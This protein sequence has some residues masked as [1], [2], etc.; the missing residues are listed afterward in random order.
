MAIF[1]V[2]GPPAAGKTTW[3]LDNARHGDIIIDYDRIA[4]ALTVDSDGHQHPRTILGAA[5]AARQAA[6]DHA[7]TTTAD[8]DVYI[9]HTRLTPAV[10]ARYEHIGARIVTIDPGI[11]TVLARAKHCRPW[12]TTQA[13]KDWY[14]HHAGPAPT[15]PPAPAGPPGAHPPR[16]W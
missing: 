4:A 13:I 1:V 5:R 6:I 11:N 10:R 9:I 7:L 2:T 3:V 12:Q 15:A 16:R 8:C 14:R